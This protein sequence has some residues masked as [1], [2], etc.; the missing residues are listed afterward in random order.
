MDLSIII[1][2]YNTKSDL[3]NCLKSIY[4]FTTDLRFEVIV[5]DNNSQDGSPDLIK[6]NFPQVKLVRS[7]DNLGFGKGNNLGASIAKGK[8]LLFLNSDTLLN[9]NVFKLSFDQIKDTTNLGA[10]TCRLLFTD[11]SIQPSGGYFPTLFRLFAW[12]TALD[13][14]P[15]LKQII[16]PIH[17]DISF[18]QQNFEPDWVTGA[19]M[20]IPREI[21]LKLKGFDPHIFMYGE[22]LELC[23]R[24]KKH[25]L[26]VIYS[27][28]PVITHLQS[29]SSS[30]RF[31]IVSEIKGIKY[32]FRKH[33]P[34]WQLFLVN[35][36]FKL[37][38]L[39]RLVLFGIILGNEAQKKAYQEAL[40]A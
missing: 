14:L 10:F 12:H 24:L 26:K 18:Y 40:R 13:E 1:V 37:G 29:K 11:G 21:F 16:K 2:S 7:R 19:F 39:L 4:K 30:S 28:F 15:L 6:K 31:A 5:I 25:G 20:I 22:D 17:P 23:Y 27:S 38:S 32:F 33:Q 9:D 35:L 3:K 36:L 8:Y 34:S